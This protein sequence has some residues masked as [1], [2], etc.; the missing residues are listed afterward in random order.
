MMK[1]DIIVIGASAGGVPTLINLFKTFPGL[2]DISVF[3]VL[4]LSPFSPSILPQIIKRAT[5][6]KTKHAEN[7]EQIKKGW[8]YIAPPDH[9]L[10]VDSEKI[11][12]SKG[13]KENRF[14][15]AIDVLFRSAAYSCGSRVIGIVLSGMLNDGSSGLWSVKRLGGITMIQDPE[16]ALFP[17]MPL[18]A[19]QS[20]EI[21]Y[22]IKVADMGKLIKKLNSEP[23]EA[24]AELS[25]EESKLM[26]MEILIAKKEDAFEMGILNMGEMTPFTCPECHGALVSL[27]EG[28]FIRFRCHTG[29]AF[30]PSTLL[31]SVTKSVEETLISAVR[32]LEETIMLLNLLADKYKS[33]GQEKSAQLF[34]D[35]AEELRKKS[36]LINNSV[37][38]S[39]YL[40]EDLQFVA[41]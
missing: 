10:I 22:K 17:S 6:C 11:I 36:K 16:E 35:K 25:E 38:T 32:A 28:H 26:E 29:H 41:K 14:R 27:K 20:V 30:T 5:S 2:D 15:P 9:H 13:P 40:S 1:R 24:K 8:I 39:P 23:V 12:V 19:E 3:I 34:T 33:F 4:H 21:D 7:G 37:F 31:A 18:N